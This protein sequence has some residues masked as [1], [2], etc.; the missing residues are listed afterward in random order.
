MLLQEGGELIGDG[1]DDGGGGDGSEDVYS[2]SAELMLVSLSNSYS[3]EDRISWQVIAGP[4]LALP[5]LFTDYFSLPATA[6]RKMY[7][8]LS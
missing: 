1:N 3:E 5:I 2:G 4:L 8:I 7:A 6:L